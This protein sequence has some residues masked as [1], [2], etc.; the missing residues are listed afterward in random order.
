MKATQQALSLGLDS[1]MA[2]D[3]PLMW[4]D[5]AQTWALAQQL[6]GPAL[7]D[8]IVND[9]HTCY[10]GDHHTRHDWGYGCGHCPACELRARGHAQFVGAAPGETAS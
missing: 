5:K 10:L 8:L 3:T 6:G 1:P 2:I 9:T 7:V 4:L